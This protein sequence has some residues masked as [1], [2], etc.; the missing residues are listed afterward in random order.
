[1]IS[2]SLPK[3]KGRVVQPMRKLW[4]L[5]DY[6]FNIQITD[7]KNQSFTQWSAWKDC[8]DTNPLYI[9]F[10]SYS[11]WNTSKLHFGNGLRLTVPYNGL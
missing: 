8:V 10:L 1:L 6:G 5:K 11:A 2:L 3:D 4:F 9:F 7:Q